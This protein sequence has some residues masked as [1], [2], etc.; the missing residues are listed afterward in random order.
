MEAMEIHY[1][2]SSPLQSE[3]PDPGESY[4][5]SAG[6]GVGSW[7]ELLRLV[8]FENNAEQSN[9]LML[10]KIYFLKT[11]FS[12]ELTYWVSTMYI[13]YRIYKDGWYIIFALKEFF[14]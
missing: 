2:I 10:F 6:I 4:N 14:I 1:S 7:T 12:V 3:D 13:H 8:I 5:L 11:S 9:W